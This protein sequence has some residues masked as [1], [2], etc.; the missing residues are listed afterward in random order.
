MKSMITLFIHCYRSPS[1]NIAV[2][3]YN[4]SCNKPSAWWRAYIA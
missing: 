2:I 1:F 4:T 3:N